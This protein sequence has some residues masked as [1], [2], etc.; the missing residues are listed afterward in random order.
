MEPSAYFSAQNY[1]NDGKI[2]CLVAA[3]GSVASIKLP[4]IAESLCRH[5]SISLR[6]VV[7]QSAERF[8]L[9]QS[10]EQPA[11]ESLRRIEGVDAIYRDE[12]E[13][14]KPW[15]RGDNILHIELRKVSFL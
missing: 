15:T 11:L 12:D 5:S 10:L 3:S 13:W 4:Q 8:L 2:H 9:G 7:T 14:V 1:Q 6:I